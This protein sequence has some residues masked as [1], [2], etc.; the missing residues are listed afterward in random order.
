MDPNFHIETPRLY[1]SYFI[2]SNPKHCSFLVDLYNSPLFLSSEGKTGVYTPQQAEERIRNS[3]ATGHDSHGYG[4][5]L[6]SLKTI[7]EASFAE[8]RPIGSVCLTKVQHYSAPDLGYAIIPEEN[9]KGYATEAAK[10]LLE[11]AKDVLGVTKVLGF[12]KASDIHSQRTME[13]I[14][15]E[16]RAVAVLRAFSELESAIYA[17]P[18]M[19]DIGEFGLP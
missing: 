4:Q 10:R 11:Y 5:Y 13:K 9:G 6:V 1:I 14:G 15:L 12:C 8:S 7:P 17:M 18:G 2:P 16:K 3:F 19:N